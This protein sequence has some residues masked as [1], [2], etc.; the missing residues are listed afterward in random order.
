M[1]KY[2]TLFGKKEADSK[3]PLLLLGFV[4]IFSWFLFYPLTVQAS[5][6]QHTKEQL[7]PQRIELEGNIKQNYTIT[8]DQTN[9]P[10]SFLL[11][12]GEPTGL[13]VDFWKLW[14]Q[15]NNIKITFLPLNFDES[16]E[17]IKNGQA[18]FHAGLF[19]SEERSQWAVFSLPIHRV[20]SG[21]Y[22]RNRNTTPP[23]LSEMTSHRVSVEANI[24]QED[25]LRE[26]YPHLNIVTFTDPQQAINDLLN[27]KIDAIFSEIPY[28]DAQI[29]KIGV[30]GVFT[31]GESKVAT[32]EVHALLLKKNAHFLKP[33]NKGINNIPVDKIIR[34]EKQWLPDVRP[35][36][37][38]HHSLKSLSIQQRQWLKANSNFTIGV[39]SSWAPFEYVNDKNRYVGLSSEY[40]DTL[41]TKLGITLEPNLDIGWATAFEQLKSGEIDLMPSVSYTEERAKSVLFTEPYLSLPSVITTREDAFYV[42]GMTQLY[43]KRVGVVRGYIYEELIRRDHPKIA[44]VTFDTLSD[45]LLA[46]ERG[47]IDAYVDALAPINQEITLRN[48]TEI[49]IAAFIPYDLEV[50]MALRKGLEEFLPILNKAL[51]NLTTQEKS[52]MNN[53]WLSVEVT[54]T[55]GILKYLY[56]VLPIFLA[57]LLTITFVLRSN[58][59]LSKEISARYR[60]EKSLEKAKVKAESANK[61]KD[62]FLANMSHEIRTP[63][64]AVIG[65]SHLLAQS[66]LKPQQN[67]YLDTLRSSAESLLVLINDILDL[68]KVE[69]GKIDLEQRPFRLAKIFTNVENQMKLSVDSTK[70]KLSFEREQSIPEFLVGDELR[71]NQILVNLTSNAVKFTKDGAI[72]VSVDSMPSTHQNNS[73]IELKFCVADTGIGLTKEQIEK[74][75]TSYN[76]ADSSTTRK[77]GGTGLGLAICK[78][79]TELMDG[80]IWAESEY[81]KGSQFYFTIKLYQVEDTILTNPKEQ[82]L[83]T[84]N[85][86]SD[87]AQPNKL[88][89][90]KTE[91][92]DLA[93]GNGKKILVV[94]D[95]PVNLT[96]AQK[97]LENANY[98]V[99][100]AKNGRE[101]IKDLW[102]NQYDAV[103]MDIQMPQMDG[104]QATRHIREEMKLTQLPIIA[105]SANVMQ[106][107]KDLSQAAGM[108]EHLGKPL[109]INRLLLVL[110]QLIK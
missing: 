99:V 103:L 61:S 91:E 66:G 110:K 69:A 68:S 4:S 35:Y 15:E 25:Y 79:L 71:I 77:Y 27:Q 19:S 2:R 50:S 51:S 60:V 46:L 87:N 28:L 74:L 100:T 32:N 73:M 107:D 88:P 38:D 1:S 83:E 104:Y 30:R 39:D 11:P 95:N 62:E 81:G 47:E 64:N 49:T 20:D 93:Q 48:L 44:L 37:S 55:S 34:L 65:M 45:G 24:F 82:L 16:I 86:I 14:S 31:I 89:P 105:L 58:R 108:N 72:R 52:E 96:I 92:Q 57:L 43:D 41:Q 29:A 98:Q 5:S 80:E 97:V 90:S 63:M 94:D 18:D 85:S 8:F 3:F 101:A 106:K 56:I 26:H 70:V 10:F 21:V 13:Y 78:K 17:A 109:D 84:K 54:L 42:E 67:E 7:S 36:F 22:F 9:I 75:F 102:L 23:K 6:T 40:I 53:R 33:I 59:K 12:D 76:Q